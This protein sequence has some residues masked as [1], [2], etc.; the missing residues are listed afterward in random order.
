[1][2]TRTR[3]V[4]LLALALVVGL[5]IVAFGTAQAQS[6]ARVVLQIDDSDSVVAPGTDVDV[7][8]WVRSAVSGK[9]YSIRFFHAVGGPA[10]IDEGTALPSDEQPGPPSTFGTYRYIATVRLAVPLGSPYG[11]S[12]L[13]VVVDESDADETESLPL[14]QTTLTIGDAGDPI[15]SARVSSAIIGFKTAGTRSSTSLRSA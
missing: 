2:A 1:M 3:V 10:V 4:A 9:T 5:W 7:H 8:I 13:S 6:R 15:G 14:E 12:T 11:K